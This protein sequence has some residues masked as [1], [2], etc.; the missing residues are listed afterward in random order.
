MANLFP[1]DYASCQVVKK[2]LE[3]LA[4]GCWRLFAVELH[5]KRKL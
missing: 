2:P 5:G 4:T 3:I 1:D